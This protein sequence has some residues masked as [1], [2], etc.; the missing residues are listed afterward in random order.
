[1]QEKGCRNKKEQ[2]QTETHKHD[3]MGWG[4]IQGSIEW[5]KLAIS[6]EKE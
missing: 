6:H 3:K 4:N 1:M 2:Q 5:K